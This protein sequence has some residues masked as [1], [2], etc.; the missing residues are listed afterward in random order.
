MSKVKGVGGECNH[1]E[2]ALVVVQLLTCS[3]GKAKQGEKEKQTVWINPQTPRVL[4]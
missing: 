2:N 4:Y 3:K 1:E